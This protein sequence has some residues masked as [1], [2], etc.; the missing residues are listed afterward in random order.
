MINNFE[1]Y[2]ANSLILIVDDVPQNLQIL[3]T[4]LSKE[5]YKIAFATN[6][7][8]ALSNAVN[9]KPQLIL[10]DINMPDMD[11]IEVSKQIKIIEHLKDTPIIFISA[12]NHPKDIVKG[13]K[14]GGSDYI[15]KP[16]NSDELLA[17]VHIQFELIYSR[18]KLN[19]QNSNLITMQQDLARTS[20]ELIIKNEIAEEQTIELK[21]LNA[22][23]NKLFSI[24]S[25]DLK[26]PLSGISSLI[27]VLLLYYDKI[28]NDEKREKINHLGL[29]VFNVME[30]MEKLFIWSSTQLESF[31]INEYKEKLWIIVENA[32]QG[33]KHNYDSKDIELI[34]NLN[35][36]VYVSS[37]ISM[38]STVIR[39]LLSNAV[40]FTNR[41]GT[42]TIDC[43]DNGKTVRISISDNGVGMNEEM[44]KSLF[45][46]DSKTSHRGT[47]KET[48]TGLGLIIC[49]EM[50]A[51]HDKELIVNS[52]IGKGT[53]FYF[54]L[55]KI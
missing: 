5:N 18:Y 24:I 12:R 51:K 33:I 50:I 7:K 11:G 26:G 30:M 27:E 35:R 10:L 31:S 47:E 43:K 53:T 9:L 55:D 13:F 36:D 3:G 38:I 54:D 8:E 46:A 21:E 4:I 1:E 41:G 32:I 25:H 2:K 44:V 34:V 17:R 23:K 52:E 48:G 49:H 16:F 40:K 20:Q 37:D 14:A 28:S 6:G 15:T 42:V 19:I 45:R 39:N 29:A 22:Q